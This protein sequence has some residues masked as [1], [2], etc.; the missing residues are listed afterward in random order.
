MRKLLCA[1]L[2]LLGFQSLVFSQTTGEL[3]GIIT[4]NSKTDPPEYIKVEVLQN[5]IYVDGIM[6]DS[7]GNYWIKGIPTGTYSVRFSRSGFQTLLVTDVA[8]ATDI[9]YTLSP[10]ISSGQTIEGVEFSDNRLRTDKTPPGRII[11]D[12]QDLMSIPS[13][14]VLGVVTQVAGVYSR[15]GKFGSFSGSRQDATI[16]INGVK[17]RNGLAII[18]RGGAESVN[19]YVVGGVIEITMR[20]I[21]NKWF[22]SAEVRTSKLMDDY[23]HYYFSGTVGGPLFKKKG[24]TEGKPILGFI[25]SF[26]GAYDKDATPGFLGWDHATDGTMDRI[27]NDPLRLPPAGQGGTRY[28][29]EYLKPDDFTNSPFRMNAAS[30]YFNANANFDL[31]PAKNTFISFGGYM[32]ASQTMLW[33]R[34]NSMFNSENNGRNQSITGNVFGR[35]V[36]YF[37]GKTDEKGNIKGLKNAMVS[38]QIDCLKGYSKSGDVRHQENFFNYGYVGKFK[39]FEHQLMFT[40]MI[41]KSISQVI[42]LVDTRTPLSHLHHQM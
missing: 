8:I 42:Y 17:I 11:F 10:E 32:N 23:G 31:S 24:K 18:P 33:D 39:N 5:D 40:G 13:L 35:I 16:F 26:E 7:S 25:L 20:N 36:Q 41:Q 6:S 15:D 12:H 3:K 14:N 37:Q 9:I 2:I 28:N 38:L 4:S 34:N 30:Q 29:A 27:I 21:A 1:A 19:V 22:G